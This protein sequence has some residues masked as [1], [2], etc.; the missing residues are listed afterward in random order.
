MK[1]HHN[2]LAVFGDDIVIQNE[3]DQYHDR[4]SNLGFAYQL[5]D[6]MEYAS[7]EAKSFLAGSYK[8]KVL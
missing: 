8:F 6:D 4:Y 1:G 3:A 7:E 5:P 2:G